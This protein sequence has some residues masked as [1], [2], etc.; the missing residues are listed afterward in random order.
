M[1]GKALVGGLA[2]VILTQVSP[3]AAEAAGSPSV[4]G[5]AEVRRDD[6]ESV[7]VVS[8][9]AR[10]AGEGARG[11]FRLEHRYNGEVAWFDGA[12]DCLDVG[13]PVAVVTGVVGRVHK[14][15]GMKRGDRFSFTVLDDGG[16][17]RMGFASGA[18]AARCLGPAPKAEITG[19]D[20]VV[21]D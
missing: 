12:V 20:I 15:G 11:T 14:I 13:R 5:R 8:V 9:N 7:F 17:D 4:V 18:G 2:A 3:S 6:P 10:G 1:L 16:R 19:G 21:R